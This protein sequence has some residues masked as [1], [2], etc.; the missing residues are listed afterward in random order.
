M[1]DYFAGYEMF[2]D[3]PNRVEDLQDDIV[4]AIQRRDN[5]IGVFSNKLKTDRPRYAKTISFILMSREAIAA[6]NEWL[7][8]RAGR[9]VP[10]WFPSWQMDIALVRDIEPGQSAMRI[11]HMGY[12]QN[13]LP[14]RGR[15][16]IILFLRGGGYLTEYIMA[17]TD[18]GDGTESL[19]FSS[20][21]ATK[22]AMGDVIM[23]SFVYLVRLDTDQITRRW[24]TQSIMTV[25]FPVIEVVGEAEEIE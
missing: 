22:I 19:Y 14:S 25:S 12:T 3:E 4:R 8:R 16:R 18:N 5:R 15:R 7:A 23:T 24:E 17:A 13:Y 9:L 20:P 2:L 10:F 21:F 11:E 1:P 6:H